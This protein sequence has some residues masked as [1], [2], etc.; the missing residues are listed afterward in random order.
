L[1]KVTLTSGIE[2]IVPSPNIL[3]AYVK[4]CLR[5]EGGIERL[6]F[7]AESYFDILTA[8]AAQELKNGRPIVFERDATLVPG[9]PD[10]IIQTNHKPSSEGTGQYGLLRS[11]NHV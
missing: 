4:E 3:K 5:E 6:V 2:L 1:K 9:Y 7:N 8:L 11:P 10:R